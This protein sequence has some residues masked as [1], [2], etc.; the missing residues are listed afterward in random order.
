MLMSL[1][2]GAQAEFV[3]I[4]LSNSPLVMPLVEGVWYRWSF[5]QLQQ[6]YPQWCGGEWPPRTKTSL[7]QLF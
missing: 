2:L 4:P 7:L 5:A 6:V 1:V 3:P